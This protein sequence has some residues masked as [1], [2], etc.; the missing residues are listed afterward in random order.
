MKYDELKEK[1]KGVYF[2][3]KSK[4]SAFV[5]LVVVLLG[6]PCLSAL[7]ISKGFE[8]AITLIFYPII[9]LV[10]IWA[11]FQ[12]AYFIV[13]SFV[14]YKKAT[15]D[16]EMQADQTKFLVF[17]PAHNE[18]GVLHSTLEN[19][20]KADYDKTLYNIVVIDDASVDQ[21]GNIARQSGVNVLDTNERRFKEIGVGKPKALQYAFLTYKES[22]ELDNYDM[23]LVLD[24]DNY[25]SPNLF[26]ELNA[27]YIQKGQPEAIQTYLDSKNHENL[28]SLGYAASYWTMNRFFQLAKY[29]LGLPNSI[30]GTGFAVSTKWLAQANGFASKS[31]TED[32]EMEIRI[33]EDGGRILWNHFARIYDEKPTELKAA[34]IQRYRWSK[35]HWYV[36]FT[37]APRLL[38]RLI[39]ERKYRYL[40]QLAYLFSMRENFQLILAIAIA[41]TFFFEMTFSADTHHH[42]LLFLSESYFIPRYWLNYFVLFYGF[43]PVTVGYLRDGEEKKS[44]FSVIKVNIA[45]IYF[46]I[47]YAFCQL[48]GLFNLRNQGSWTKTTHKINYEQQ[49]QLK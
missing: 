46:S 31:L 1:Y 13:L 38:K 18:E 37:H 21:T 26:K 22:G 16:Y 12:I 48:W 27:Q 47:T 20:K 39:V 40:D 25:V 11:F 34:M 49:P 33:V 19:I 23:V 36:A 43:I 9:L 5:V 6:I 45:L 35:G 44:I 15:R 7:A 17:I 14:G 28:L 32:L 29:R 41:V 30:G 8:S 42:A 4:F 24:A 3:L 10:A 2:K